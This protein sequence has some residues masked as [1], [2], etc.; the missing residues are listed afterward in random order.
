MSLT[1]H[2]ACLSA[3]QPASSPQTNQ[4]RFA[5]IHPSF[6]YPLFP[7]TRNQHTL[8]LCAPTSVDLFTYTPHSQCIQPHSRVPPLRRR[9]PYIRIPLKV[10]T[11][12][13][14]TIQPAS[15]SSHTPPHS[16]YIQI[17]SRVPT[18]VHLPMYASHSQDIPPYS[19]RP[20]RR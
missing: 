17:H 3:T 13:F 9:S 11:T 2:T 7:T 16:K 15:I 18:G 5:H 8:T 20:N 10:H 6:P 19:P 12:L 1:I 4:R 14:F